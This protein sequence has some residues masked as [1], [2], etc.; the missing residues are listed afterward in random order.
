MPLIY[1]A[2]TAWEAYRSSYQMLRDV[3]EET[4]SSVEII[5]QKTQQ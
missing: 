4:R 5:I 1:M 2:L 3:F